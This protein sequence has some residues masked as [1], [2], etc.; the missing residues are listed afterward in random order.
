MDEGVPRQLAAHLPDHDVTTVPNAGW[1][2]VKNGELLGLIENTG[3]RAF[4]SCDLNIPMQQGHLERRPFAV[5]LLTTNHWPTM[6]PHTGLIAAALDQSEPG[7]IETV[8]CGKFIA[9]KFRPRT[10][11]P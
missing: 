3:F 11:Q 6:E 10:P 8:D 1:A 7:K 4:V 9:R 2:G 5:L